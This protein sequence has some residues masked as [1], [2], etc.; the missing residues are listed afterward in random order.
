MK[1]KNPLEEKQKKFVLRTK[2]FLIAATK[3]LVNILR[4]HNLILR[5]SIVLKPGVRSEDWA[6]K[7][8][9]ILSKELKVS[10][11]KDSSCSWTR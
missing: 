8:I 2:S 4:L 11:Y 6:L 5:R 1:L 10:G 7:A 9:R 3:H